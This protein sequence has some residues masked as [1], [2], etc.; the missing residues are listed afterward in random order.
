MSSSTVE[1]SILPPIK[2]PH[3]GQQSSLFGAFAVHASN[4]IQAPADRIISALLETANWPHWNLFVPSADTDL[5]AGLSGR[6]SPGTFFTEHVDMSGKGKA[7][8]L[9]KMWM[10]SEEA[11]AP[12][13]ENK[14]RG[15]GYRVVWV[16]KQFPD[17]AL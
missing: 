15:K 9:Q 4:T 14:S 2:T 5:P 17:W 12:T 3:W 6:L 13:E 11:I 16:G 10:M 8:R 7:S 1:A